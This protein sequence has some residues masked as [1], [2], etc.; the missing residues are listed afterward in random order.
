MPSNHSTYRKL[1]ERT[2]IGVVLAASSALLLTLAFPPY[3]IW[4]LIWIGFVP[5]LLAQ[6][7]LMPARHA[8]LAPAVAIGGWLG[9]FMI[10][11]FANIGT[12]MQ[13]LPL[14]IGGLILLFSSGD[15][16]FHEHTRY[17]WFILHGTLTWVGLEMVRSFIPFMGT[18]AFVG[19]PLYR[20]LWLI[21][22]VSVFSIYG[23]DLL[24]L[25][26]NYALAQWVFIRFDR[27]WLLAPSVPSPT[28][29][30]TQRWL[31]GVLVALAVWIGLSI[32]LQ[33][34]GAAPTVRVAALHL[35][36]GRPRGQAGTRFAAQT[37]EADRQG[38]QFIVWPEMALNYDP[39]VEHTED[40]KA[41]A[42]QTSAYL[43][44]GYFVPTGSQSH[45]NEATIL[46]PEGEFLGVFGKDHPTVFIGEAHTS[47][48]VYP[49]YDTD[50]GR[51]ATIICYDLDFTDTARKMARHGAQIIAAPSLDGPSLAVQHY[52]MAV[53]R[54][55]E[56]RVTIIKSD[57][58]GSDSVIVD[59]YGRIL[60]SAITPEGGEAV[61]VTDAPL[62][63]GDALTVRLGDWVGWISLG[64][65]AFF[66]VFIPVTMRKQPFKKLSFKFRL[67]GMVEKTKSATRKN[68]GDA[69]CDT[70]L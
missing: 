38:A 63:A 44:I 64:G 68:K 39:Q 43:A 61:L 40:F 2:I 56:N 66:M 29:R 46:S 14:A 35:D 54:A 59:P 24:I 32:A 30:S 16:P 5:M 15:R 11:I 69:P 25:L 6:Y 13:W 67:S 62:G 18:W 58:S 45:R 57:S 1:W 34:P 42:A 21:Q 4:P 48:G 31:F 7:R 47:L 19:Y 28:A 50:L 51:L 12:Y 37:L 23:L 20:Q 8:S 49:V 26:V 33:R 36:A 3:N 9:A 55:I 10:P 41:L 52:S 22:P 53:F 70:N 65:L 60:A 17:H 27:R